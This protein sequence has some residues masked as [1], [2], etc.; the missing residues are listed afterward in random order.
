MKSAALTI[1]LLMSGAAIAQSTTTTTTTTQPELDVD[2]DVG[3]QP[4]GDRDVDAD[5]DVQNETT[6]TTH[7]ATPHGTSTTTHSTEMPAST[8]MS[9]TTQSTTNT[10]TAT[11]STTWS[12]TATM[13]SS[14]APASGAV[15]QPGNNNPETDARG[16][17]VMSDPANVPAGFNGV[18]TGAVGGPVE[19]TDASHPPC[20]RTV[21]DN[22]VQT[23]ERGGR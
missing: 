10:G 23:Y 5:V 7:S 18:A 17:T 22:C 13:A 11:Q 4:D 14:M 3:V 20:S 8:D 1:A 21:T 19:A 12:G 6:T 16:V 9:T 2:A 15:V